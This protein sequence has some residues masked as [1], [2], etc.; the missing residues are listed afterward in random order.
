MKTF[1]IEASEKNINWVKIN[2]DDR[3]YKIVND[4]IVITYFNEMQKNDILNAIK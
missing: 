1:K 3:D 4:E 2:L